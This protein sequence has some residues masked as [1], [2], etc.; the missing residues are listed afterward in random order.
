MGVGKVTAMSK[1]TK[2]EY[3]GDII[4]VPAYEGDGA[5]STHVCPGQPPRPIYPDWDDVDTYG[6]SA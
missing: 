6:P 4:E 2:C 5:Y 3:C 1:L